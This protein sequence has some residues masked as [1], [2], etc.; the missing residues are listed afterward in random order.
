MRVDRF[1]QSVFVTRDEKV[2]CSASVQDWDGCNPY[3]IAASIDGVRLLEGRPC[4]QSTAEFYLPAVD[5]PC[6][7]TLELSPFR[8]TSVIQSFPYLPPKPWT[9]DF[10]LSSHED[11]GYCAYANTLGSEC[12]DYL[13]EAIRLA[14]EDPEYAYMIEHYW[15]LRGFEDYR[16]EEQKRR[17]KARMQN[18][19]IA[20]SAPHCSNHTHWQGGEQLVRALYYACRQAKKTWGISPKTVVYADIAGADWSCVSA[21]AGAGIRYLLLLANRYLRFST[22]DQPLPRVFWWQ[23]PNGKDRLLCFRQEGYK[24]HSIQRAMGAASSQAKGGTP[25]YFDRSRME[26]TMRAVD[27]MVTAFGDV[28]YDRIPVSF[29]MDREYP[30][31]DMKVVCDAMNAAWKYPRF[32][33]STPDRTFAYIEETAGEKLPVLSGDIT[34]QWADFAAISP[35]WF[36]RKREAQ[37]LFPLAETFCLTRMLEEPQVRWPAARL[38]EALWKMCEFDDHCWATS[39]K[40]PQEMHLFNLNLVK[41]ETAC[42]SLR[43][44]KEIVGEQLGKP[45]G[46]RF[47]LFNPLPFPRKATLRLPACAVPADLACQATSDGDVLTQ[48][49]ELPAFGYRAFHGGPRAGIRPPEPDPA[50]AFETPFYTVRLDRDGQRIESIWDKAL[51]RELLDS[52]SAYAF[53]EFLYVHAEEKHALP[54]TV[55]YPRRRGMSVRV[56][57]LATE[58][59]LDSFE[60][61]SG[62]NVRVVLTFYRQEKNIDVHLSFRNAAGLMGDYYDRYK[63]SLFFAFP[64]LV[65]NHRFCTELSGGIV[66]ERVD[67]MPVNP[68]DFV[69]A[70]SWIS[71]EN[72]DW[73][74]GLFCREMPLFHPGGI[75]YNR[76][77][78]R[79]DYGESSSVFL[80]AASNRTNNLNY[81][82]PEDCRGDFHVSVLPFSGESRAVLPDW[83]YGKLCPPILGGPRPEQSRSYLSLDAKNLR[84]LCMKPAEEGDGWV[85][86]RLMEKEGR[87]AQARLT[88]PFAI[89]DARYADTVE[90]PLADAPAFERNVVRLTAQPF[91]YVNLLLRPAERLTVVPEPPAEGVKNVFT[92]PVENRNTVLCFEKCGAHSRAYSIREGDREVTQIRDEPYRIQQ[93]TLPGIAYQ[94]LQVVPIA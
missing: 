64:F 79:V 89:E 39:S 28:P 92:F 71:V 50:C 42:T 69:M 75:H 73:G 53:G 12:A 2:K 20:L 82:T 40:H 46:G 90:N 56:G 31:T 44:L 87:E 60:E 26:E 84:L 66:D 10:F 59:V 32:R 62:A 41:R 1:H 72:G 34:D 61:Q 37:T 67:R 17:L 63:K 18:G 13:D 16:D 21:Y 38:D 86:L 25:Y 93:C 49:V 65:E 94:A 88:L 52:A 70:H 24:Q 43:I 19:Q 9:I 8:D 68:H 30:N 83:S 4:W 80:Y 22:D 76:I 14:E 5:K 23:A 51:R 7:V 91:S 55:E 45:S 11:L 33:L 57:P 36:A 77:S 27:E 6:R 81:R 58:V 78:A 48:S 29:Y 47:S 3:Y 35:E 54:V 15:W 85:F 74:I